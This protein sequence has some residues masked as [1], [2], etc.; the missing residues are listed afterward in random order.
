MRSVFLSVCVG[1]WFLPTVVLAEEIKPPGQLP[2][3]AKSLHSVRFYVGDGRIQAVA[4][5]AG[6]EQET[7]SDQ[8]MSRREKLVLNTNDAL[9]ASIQYELSGGD[10]HLSVDVVDGQQF[11]VARRPA[12]DAKGP[13]DRIP[14]TANRAADAERQRRS[15]RSRGEGRIALAL[16]PGRTRLEPAIFTA[17]VRNVSTGLAVDGIGAGG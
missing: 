17:A 10:E 12:K 13:V 7:S 1:F 15:D 3:L 6:V 2:N 5:E 11:T 9:D 4:S 8:G 16:D 14:P